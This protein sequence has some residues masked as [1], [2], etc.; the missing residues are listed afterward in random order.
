MGRPRKWKND[1]E[2][3]RAK[4]AAQKAEQADKPEAQKPARPREIV[5]SDGTTLGAAR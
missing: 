5:L 2:R 3:M 1:A 4:R